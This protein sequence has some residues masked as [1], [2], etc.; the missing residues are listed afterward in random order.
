MT[1]VLIFLIAAVGV[2]LTVVSAR[3]ALAERDA[4]ERHHRTLSAL[5]TLAERAD[6]SRP[7]VVAPEGAYR[8]RHRKARPSSP[9]LAPRLPLRAGPLALAG[10]GC[11]VVAAAV[12]FLASRHHAPSAPGQA[13]RNGVPTATTRPTPARATST[14]TVPPA[15]L[16][17][18][19]SDSQ[20][21]RYQVNR[22]SVDLELVPSAACWVEIKSALGG[23]PTV[24]VGTLRPGSHQAVPTG[25]TTGGV[26]V[27]LGNP[28]AMSVTV[29]GAAL[30][31]PLASS[32]QPFTLVFQP[33][34]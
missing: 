32:T 1:P 11:V 3:R 22:P 16:V 31:V 24:F 10:I 17:L 2:A 13:L 20:Q 23:G 8:P 5:G 33:A 30:P 7:V 26:S 14:T 25:P 18:L 29:D 6:G 9:R 19:S 4:V 27:R 34:G 15:S 28:G 12:W 21:A